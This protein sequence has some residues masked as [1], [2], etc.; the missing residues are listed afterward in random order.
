MNLD[1]GQKVT[2]S[3]QSRFDSC[4]LQFVFGGGIGRRRQSS[5]GGWIRS[6]QV[7]GARQLHARCKSS[8]EYFMT[9]WQRGLLRRPAKALIVFRFRGSNPLSVVLGRQ[10]NGRALDLQSGRLG[11]NPTVSTLE[12]QLSWLE[13]LSDKQEVG[14]SNLSGSTLEPQLSWDV[15]SALQAEGQ[16]FES[17]W[18][19]FRTIAQR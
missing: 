18:L 7:V 14:S 1:K 5:P 8:S 10:L 3:V 9:D 12:P 4:R 17:L 11:S 19:Y 6:A 2:S 13:R 16:E 15:A